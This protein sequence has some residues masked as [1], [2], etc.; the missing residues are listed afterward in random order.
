MVK[1]ANSK[2]CSH[3]GEYFVPGGAYASHTQSCASGG[4]KRRKRTRYR[5][6]FFAHNGPGPY[7]CYFGCGEPVTFQ[8]VIVHHTDDDFT[9]DSITNLAPAHRVCHNGHHFTELWAERREEL[10]GSPTRGNRKPH[11]EE[12]KRKISETKKA[13]SQ[14]PTQE[15]RDKAAL[16]RRTRVTVQGGDVL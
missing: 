15:A 4:K 3:C 7:I 16:A 10:L 9:N 2:E 11:S 12:T 6:L 14:A 1:L 13:R 5:E 8:E